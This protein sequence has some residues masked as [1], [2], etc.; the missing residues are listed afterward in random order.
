MSGTQICL[1]ET[2][3]K[4]QP[5]VSI[6]EGVAPPKAHVLIKVIRKR[7]VLSP[8]KT[9]RRQKEQM[10]TQICQMKLIFIFYRESL[11]GQK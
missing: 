11:L 1:S 4:N 6:P 10:S 9:P 8:K 5:L 7:Q 2:Y 3:L